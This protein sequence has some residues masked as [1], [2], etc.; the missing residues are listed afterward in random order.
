MKAYVIKL[1]TLFLVF[2]AHLYSSEPYF[3]QQLDITHGLSQSKVNWIH[4][5]YKGY[6]WIGT[7]YGLNRF[8]RDG[9]KSF[10]HSEN[11]TSSLPSNEILFIQEDKERNLWIGTTR[12]VCKFDRNHSKFERIKY[13]GN[14]LIAYSVL[15]FRDTL[16]FGGSEQIFMYKDDSHKIEM[17]P[18]HTAQKKYTNFTE[19]IPF[20]HESAI[21]NTALYGIYNYNFTNH[22]LTKLEYV[23]EGNTLK[24]FIDSE[25]RLW[26]SIY[27]KGVYCFQNGKEVKHFTSDNS[28]LSYN[29]ILSMEEKDG[30]LWLGTDGGGIQFISLSD[31]T[32]NDVQLVNKGES[33]SKTTA[34]NC[35]YKDPMNNMWAGTVRSG[36][37]YIYEVGANSYSKVPMN[38]PYGLSNQTINCIYE[39]KKGHIWL[40]TDGGGLNRYDT[41]TREF[42]HYPTTMNEKITSIIEYSLSELMV[43]CF[44]KGVYIINKETGAMRPFM[45]Y[46]RETRNQSLKNGI[47]TFLLELPDNK[48]LFCDVNLSVYDKTTHQFTVVAQRGKEFE[49][50]S[51]LLVKSKDG[52]VYVVDHF[53]I[54]QYDPQ[55]QK[56]SV[57]YKGKDVIQNIAVDGRKNIWI[58]TKSGLIRYARWSNKINRIRPDILKSINSVAVDYNNFLWIGVSDNKLFLYDISAGLLSLL[59]ESDGFI[60]NEYSFG[61]MFVSSQGEAFIG[62]SMGLTIT[63]K[64]MTEKQMAHVEKKKNHIELVDLF[65]NGKPYQNTNW[66]NNEAIVLPWNFNSLQLKFMV[67]E[68]NIFKKHAFRY[69]IKSNQNEETIQS[70]SHSLTIHALREG[71]HTI[72]ASYITQ[73]GVWSKPIVVARVNV[74]PPWWKSGYFYMAV[75]ICVFVIILFIGYSMFNHE[76]K[77]RKQEISQLNNKA[78]QD[79]IRFLVNIG[80]ELKTPLTLISAPLK[81]IIEQDVESSYLSQKLENIYKQ[82]IKI[83]ELVD[84]VLDTKKLESGEEVLHLVA[85]P[86]NDWIKE[87][88]A[89]FEDEMN[90]H[91]MR[92]V[93]HL[94]ERIKSVPFDKEKCRLIINNLVMNAIKFSEDNT[95]ITIKTQIM[96][97]HMVRISVI[98]EGVGLKDEV[99]PELFSFYYQGQEKQSGSSIGLSYCKILTDLHNGRIGAYRNKDKGSTFYFELPLT[100]KELSLLEPEIA[101]QCPVTKDD[102]KLLKAYSILLI[103]EKSELRLYLKD[104]L[105]DYFNHVFIAKSG[106]EGLELIHK[107][108]PDIVASDAIMSGMSGFMVCKKMKEDEKV[109]HIP[110]ILLTAYYNQTNMQTGYRMGA[111]SFM[112]KPFEINTLL[113]VVSNQLKLRESIKHRYQ[114]TESHQSPT[115]NVSVNN[116]NEE[117]MEKLNAII[118]E[119]FINVDLNVDFL[120]KEMGIGRTALFNK[121]KSITNLGIVD[122]I[123]GIRI[124]KSMELLKDSNF[125]ISEI[126]EK[127]GFSYPQY[128]GKVFKKQM[129]MSPSEYRNKFNS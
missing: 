106:V 63:D 1:L 14:Q 60:T 61:S 7:P 129:K 43:F 59:S 13:E 114:G 17:L 21:V 35:L 80:H 26:V 12:G 3:F 88:T 94:D 18:L 40:G 64:H 51:P 22:Q 31:L 81:Q 120:T 70:F 125:N 5:D 72:S 68:E 83:K 113:S 98:D 28:K 92:M 37:V 118:E 107:N 110:F 36:A 16:Y 121:V 19:M 50:F 25:Q 91:F 67:K 65:V 116:A 23:P 115:L 54:L 66:E 122:Y 6:L 93:Y 126:S 39:G 58:A 124:R 76:E 2:S 90:R 56:L 47:S 4:Y 108:N 27:G 86:L 75:F 8:D 32:I 49:R 62:G 46:V 74:I 85:N 96:G 42:K 99:I 11:D 104:A 69:I 77:K 103:I 101:V 52:D 119:N 29:V 79:R 41:Q 15:M 128:F 20:N 48:I 89:H 57:C 73:E 9:I 38:T 24:V 111:D 109:C 117:F 100:S 82:S 87:A 33:H 97:T 95:I 34:V 44:N 78:T 102:Y 45:P 105:K 112:S 123:N 30:Q 127:V 84:M 53:Q 10:F 55:T 71:S